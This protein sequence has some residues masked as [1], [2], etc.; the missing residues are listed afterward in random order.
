MRTKKLKVN[1]QPIQTAPKDGTRFLGFC[2]VPVYNEDAG[3]TAVEKEHVVAYW[4]GPL[5]I[6]PYP[7]RGTITKGMRFTHWMPLPEPPK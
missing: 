2:E 3:N 7:Y 4:C 1:W 6:L 5:G